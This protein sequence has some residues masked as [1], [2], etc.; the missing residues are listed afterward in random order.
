MGYTAEAGLAC[1]GHSECV[2]PILGKLHLHIQSYVDA[3][4]F[5]IM[6]LEGCDVL[7][8]IP[9]MYRVHGVLN[10]YDKTLTLSHKGKT[11]ELDVKLKGESIPL[12][13][14]SAITSVIK[15]HLSVYLVF[16]QDVNELH[17]SSL[18]VVDKDRS[19]FLLKFNDC[20]SDS[21]PSQLPPERSEDH[22]IDLIPGSSPPNRPPYRVS[23]AQQKEILSQVNELLEK[24]LIQ[25]SSSPFCSPVLLVQKKDGSWRMCIDYRALN[26]NTIKN[27]FPIPRIDDI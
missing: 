9:W 1:P 5:Y 19:E 7:L 3:E 25:P 24:G 27:R 26:K 23:A 21:L 18:S 20:F 4:E 8:G 14:A 2:T 22:M 13:S 10:A 17:E 15:N 11:H 6:P 16:V 12:V